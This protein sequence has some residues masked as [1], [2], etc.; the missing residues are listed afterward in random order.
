MKPVLIEPVDILFFRDA[1]PMSAGQGK[2]AG[3]RIPFPSSF[4]E[5]LRSTLLR[6]TGQIPDAKRVPGRPKNAPRSGNWHQQ[7]YD[8]KTFI[9]TRAFR[10]LRTIGPL[11]WQK[12]TGLL[13]PVPLDATLHEG[14]IAKCELICYSETTAACTSAAPGHYRPVCLPVAVTP[15]DKTAE[16]KGWWT[17]SQY[18]AYLGCNGSHT[19]SPNYTGNFFQPTPTNNLWEPEYRIGIEIDPTSFASKHGQLY[20]GVYLRPHEKTRFIAWIGLADPANA[21]GTEAETRKHEQQQI[22][23]LDSLFLGGEFRIARLIQESSDGKPL[24]D[25][26]GSLRQ[27]PQPPPT[28]GPCLMKWVL[29]TPAVFAHGS[30]PGWCADNTVSASQPPHG[31]VRLTLPGRARLVS[32][33][34]GKP[35]TVSGWDI[36]DGA[37]KPTMLAVP[38]GSVY[39]FLCETANTAAALARKL[40]WQPRSDYYGE[41]GCG[42][43]FVSFDVRLHPSSVQ[44]DQLAKK[45]FL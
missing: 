20:A 4:H 30:L 9:G 21:T 15:P 1:I 17:S 13:M 41:K 27:P 40:H 36:I 5:S 14:S 26:L 22:E 16:L 32:W 10:S 42:Y 12:E 29:I 7:E 39:Y 34:I 8:N 19:S 6:I 25:P 45:L 38:E 35:Q 3:C 28:N 23:N 43:G 2:G 37:P 24:P 18:Q 31:F 44:I 11:P 33:C